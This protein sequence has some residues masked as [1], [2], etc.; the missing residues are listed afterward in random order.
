MPD[1]SQD[2]PPAPTVPPWLERATLAAMQHAM[3]RALAWSRTSEAA[4]E[5][6]REVARAHLPAATMG[7]IAAAVAGVVPDPE[8]LTPRASSWRPGRRTVRSRGRSGLS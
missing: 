5:A 7:M 2:A 6:A 4:A 1:A 3:N 8:G